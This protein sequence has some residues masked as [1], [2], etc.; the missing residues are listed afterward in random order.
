MKNAQVDWGAGTRE[1]PIFYLAGTWIFEWCPVGMT[2]S[3]SLKLQIA[4]HF[5]QQVPN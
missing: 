5:E 3:R 2:D 1:S 4:L